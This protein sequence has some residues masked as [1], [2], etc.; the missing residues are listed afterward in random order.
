MGKK[1]PP[2]QGVSS[3]AQGSHEHFVWQLLDSLMEM[4]GSSPFLSYAWIGAIEVLVLVLT[5]YWVS[6]ARIAAAEEEKLS[7]ASTVA[8]AATTDGDATTVDSTA[9]RRLPIAD[10]L[11]GLLT[12]KRRFSFS[13]PALEKAYLRRTVRENKKSAAYYCYVVIAVHF[14]LFQYTGK[15]VLQARHVTDIKAIKAPF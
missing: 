13:N 12:R 6:F 5:L 11:F 3:D 7:A 1:A 4:D 15:R 8:P 2:S 14:L 9:T 10:A